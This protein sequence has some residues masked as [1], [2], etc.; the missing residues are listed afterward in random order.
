MAPNQVMTVLVVEDDDVLRQWMITALRRRHH[1]VI[2]CAN[3]YAA[4]DACRN[5]ARPDVVITDIFMP[6]ADGLE[7]TRTLSREF[8]DLPVVA[9]SGG[10][11]RL[12]GDYLQHAL[13]FGAVGAL[14]KPFDIRDLLQAIGCAVEKA[15][16]GALD[17]EPAGRD[18]GPSAQRS[19]IVERT[20]HRG[21]ECGTAA[22]PVGPS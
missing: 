21:P 9:V 10:S 5:G 3:G 6:D 20:R 7:V 18:D 15:R 14:S 4:I 16:A 19:A 13:L 2:A 22:L 8:P 17:A 12:G 11:P 1:E